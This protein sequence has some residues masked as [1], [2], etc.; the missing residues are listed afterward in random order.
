[1]SHS[2]LTVIG[3]QYCW[4]HWGL[5]PGPSACDVDVIPLHHVPDGLLELIPV[6]LFSVAHRGPIRAHERRTTS[7][8]EAASL[9]QGGWACDGRGGVLPASGRADVRAVPRPRRPPFVWAQRPA[10][11]S[12]CHLGPQH[13]RSVRLNGG[14]AG[15]PT[16]AGRGVV[17]A[18]RQRACFEWGRGGGS[19]GA[20]GST[21]LELPRVMGCKLPGEVGS[22][23]GNPVVPTQFRTGSPRLRCSGEPRRSRN[24]SDDPPQGV[25]QLEL[26]AHAGRTRVA[27]CVEEAV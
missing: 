16:L 19:F 20:A 6:F 25:G 21:S 10:S 13:G 14:G 11:P 8:A 9:Q 12:A 22:V 5:N 27:S 2:V 7:H 4:T 15:S 18:S 1:M 24:V 3:A 26:I 23:G 17:L